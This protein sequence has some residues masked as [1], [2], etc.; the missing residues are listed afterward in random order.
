MLISIAVYVIFSLVSVCSASQRSESRD[1]APG[2]R[3]C[4][5]VPTVPINRR[6]CGLFIW[7]APSA[8]LYRWCHHLLKDHLIEGKGGRMYVRFESN[9][10]LQLLYPCS[11]YS[12][13]KCLVCGG[14][15]PD[16]LELWWSKH[17]Y[18]PFDRHLDATYQAALAL[19]EPENA[20]QRRGR[21]TKAPII[22][23][24]P[25]FSFHKKYVEDVSDI[26]KEETDRKKQMQRV[27]KKYSRDQKK[28]TGWTM[29]TFPS[30]NIGYILPPMDREGD[31]RPSLT[32]LLVRSTV[33]GSFN[34]FLYLQETENAKIKAKQ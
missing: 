28:L 31:K 12:P 3:P 30:L 29:Q 24:P 13:N 10:I 18:T 33:L 2:L 23:G 26:I 4:N 21:N 7:D 9:S 22:T 20:S 16:H 5:G 25:T 27:A 32:L 34:N 19:P 6:A 14:G 1:T 8:L 17:L 15:F 11:R